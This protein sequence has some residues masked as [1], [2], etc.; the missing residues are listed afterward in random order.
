MGSISGLSL[1]SSIKIISS[2]KSLGVRFK[3]LAT[4]LRRVEA[5]DNIISMKIIFLFSVKTMKPYLP[6]CRSWL[7]QTFYDVQ[8]HKIHGFGNCKQTK[9]QKNCFVLKRLCYLL[10]SHG[11]QINIVQSLVQCNARSRRL[12]FEIE[13]CDHLNDIRR[14]LLHCTYWP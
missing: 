12:L 7:S 10:K 5:V 8:L 14:S 11:M 1:A 3:I 13:L 4:V 2:S 9:T 6:H